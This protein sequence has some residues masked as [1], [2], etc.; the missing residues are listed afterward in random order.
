MSTFRFK[1]FEVAQDRTAMKVGTDGV[2]LGAW[3]KITGTEQ[4]ILDIGTGTGLIALMMAQRSSAQNI[5]GVEIDP[6]SA[7]QASENMASSPWSSRLSVEQTPIQNFTPAQKFDL[8]VSNP[9]YFV[10]SL[11]AKGESRTIA[12]HTTE[13]SFE[14]LVK[15]VTRLLSIEGRFALILPTAEAQ[16]FDNVAE[17]VLYPTRRSFICGKRGGEI[18]R[19]MS[20]YSLTK[21]DEIID[22]KIAIRDTPPNDYSLEYRAITADFYLKF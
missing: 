18:K 2:L 13:L 10:D 3:A 22:E 9:P 1:Q 12:R 19:I 8:I 4:N 21:P 15:S 14:D 20:E 6:L 16:L 11:L 7:Q 17:G 5:I